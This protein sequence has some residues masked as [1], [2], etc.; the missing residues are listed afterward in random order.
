MANTKSAKK[1]IQIAE[2]NR[3]QNRSYK[4][5]I[6]TLMKTCLLAC[7][8]F[9]EK[10]SDNSKEYVQ[11]SLNDAFSKI[12]KAVKRGTIHKNNAANKKSRLSSSVK[13]LMESASS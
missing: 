9:K 3:L 4:S 6:K 12:D 7:G 1:R 8:S 10:P 5:S 2:R 13:K 11:K